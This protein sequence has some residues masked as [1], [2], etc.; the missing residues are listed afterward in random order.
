[1]NFFLAGTDMIRWTLDMV[2]S[3]GG[4]HHVRLT[5]QHPRGSIV[6]YFKTTETA[7]HREQELENLL[8][9]ARG[10]SDRRKDVEFAR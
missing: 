5:I 4:A 7:L 6:E 1:M 9:A 8:I 10:F 3:K 2:D